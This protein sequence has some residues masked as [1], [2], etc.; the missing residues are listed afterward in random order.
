MTADTLPFLPSYAPEGVRELA[1][2]TSPHG[3]RPGCLPGQIPPEQDL[4]E[5]PTRTREMTSF[6]TAQAPLGLESIFRA[7]PAQVCD[8]PTLLALSLYVHPKPMG[9]QGHTV[10][11]CGPA[12]LPAQGLPEECKGCSAP[13]TVPRACT[14]R[15]PMAPL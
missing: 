5:S 6:G 10:E 7:L 4:P 11:A 3:G 2:E 13:G 15:H 8:P 1:S 9:G 14:P 12:A